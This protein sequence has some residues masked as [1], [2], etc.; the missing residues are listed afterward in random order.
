V[1]AAAGPVEYDWDVYDQDQVHN[2]G[3]AHGELWDAQGLHRYMRQHYEN[4]GRVLMYRAGMIGTLSPDVVKVTAYAVNDAER[5]ALGSAS[6]QIMVAQERHDPNGVGVDISFPVSTSNNCSEPDIH[7]QVGVGAQFAWPDL[8]A[9]Y[10][11]R[12]EIHTTSDYVPGG[13]PKPLNHIVVVSVLFSGPQSYGVD[14]A[15]FTQDVCDPPPGWA[16]TQ[17]KAFTKLYEGWQASI[18]T[19]PAWTIQAYETGQ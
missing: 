18:I 16:D 9:P 4:L 12:V 7:S 1:G 15:T 13:M 8:G 19:I 3:G 17:I 10:G 2:G 11:Y 14:G 5:T 6:V